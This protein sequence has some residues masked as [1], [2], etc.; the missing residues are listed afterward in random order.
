VFLFHD[1]PSFFFIANLD[2]SL[3]FMNLYSLLSFLY[4]ACTSLSLST[5]FDFY[6]KRIV[7]NWV[8][9]IISVTDGHSLN[10][11][12]L[13]FS[14]VDNLIHHVT[15]ILPKRNKATLANYR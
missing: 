15:T 12:S 6:H 13:S 2:C 8:G 10:L 3:S 9:T 4:I 1:P 14:N 11:F 7:I 5:Y